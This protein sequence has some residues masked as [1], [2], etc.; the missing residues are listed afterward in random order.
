MKFKR[1]IC[2]HFFADLVVG[3]INFTYPKTSEMNSPTETTKNWNIVS[4]ASNPLI[5]L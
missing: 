3:D 5:T 4:S 1:T 2:P